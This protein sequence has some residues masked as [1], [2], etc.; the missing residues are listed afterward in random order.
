M[1]NYGI[2]T[3]HGGSYC[4][5]HLSNA[6]R[7][8]I[9]NEQNTTIP[10]A[11]VRGQDIRKVLSEYNEVDT[12]P[13]QHIQKEL[14]TLTIS[15][16]K[17]INESTMLD[18]LSKFNDIKIDRSILEDL[19]WIGVKCIQQISPSIPFLIEREIEECLFY[20]E[21]PSVWDNIVS[22]INQQYVEMDSRD[23]L[24]QDCTD[25]IRKRLD[26]VTIDKYKCIVHKIQALYSIFTNNTDIE[27]KYAPKIHI[28]SPNTI[29]DVFMYHANDVKDWTYHYNTLEK[30]INACEHISYCIINKIDE[31]KFD[32][33]TYL[34]NFEEV[35]SYK[36][37]YL[38][39]FI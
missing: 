13:L 9:M 32:V 35:T 16:D 5:E 29:F 36:R 22:E 25:I 6:E 15:Y 8:I 18:K 38:H 34:P 3:V 11:E 39:K 2:D 28:Y 12:W 24:K 17:F 33:N 1:K 19:K 23:W 27:I 31:Y 7:M 10:R 20:T 4:D 14:N 30:Y 21:T 37:R 26:N